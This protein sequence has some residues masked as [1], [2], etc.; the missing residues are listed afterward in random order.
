MWPVSLAQNEFGLPD[1]KL[2]RLAIAAVQWGFPP[3]SEYFGG[4]S[5]LIKVS[6][7]IFKL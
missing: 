2:K 4:G 7:K 1:E 6:K 3:N 5:E